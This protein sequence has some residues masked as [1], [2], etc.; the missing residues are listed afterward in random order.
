MGKVYFPD[1]S[2]FSFLAYLQ[3]IVTELEHKVR[4]KKDIREERRSVQIWV[5][6]KGIMGLS[7]GKTPKDRLP[8]CGE[9]P[10]LTMQI[11]WKPC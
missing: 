8:G 11:L 3:L 9:K 10:E 1:M 4:K 5:E 7:G 6:W 2:I